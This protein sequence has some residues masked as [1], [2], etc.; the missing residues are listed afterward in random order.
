MLDIAIYENFLLLHVAVSIL[1]S[2]KHINNFG[3][4]FA[5]NCL[6]HFINHSKNDLYGLEFAVYNVHLLA[7]ICVAHDD[8][9]YYDP[10]D[11]YSAF[12]FESYLGYFKKFSKIS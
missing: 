10:L 9:E 7:H 12:P 11:K 6:L 5:R 4:P 3:I 8:V 1:I 2:Q